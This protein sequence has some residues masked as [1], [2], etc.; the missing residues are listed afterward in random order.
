MEVK[1]TSFIPVEEV[2]LSTSP[3]PNINAAED[4]RRSAARILL[5]LPSLKTVD[6]PSG[7]SL[8]I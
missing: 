3:I 5:T 7:R 8:Y 2:A 4:P 6:G 1:S